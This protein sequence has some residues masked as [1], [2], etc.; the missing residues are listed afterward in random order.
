[1]CDECGINVAHVKLR[2]FYRVDLDDFAKVFKKE[3]KK[4]KLVSKE[5]QRKREHQLFLFIGEKGAVCTTHV[6]LV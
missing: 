5:K 3:Y 2:L 1:M 6:S 4:R